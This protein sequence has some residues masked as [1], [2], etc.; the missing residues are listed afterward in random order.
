MK[1]NKK[2]YSQLFTAM[3]V[4]MG[5]SVFTQC[6]KD[7]PEKEKKEKRDKALK[8]ATA[9]ITDDTVASIGNDGKLLN[10]AGGDFAKKFNDCKGVFVNNGGKEED[11]YAE[12]KKAADSQ[13]GKK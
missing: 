4:V 9:L 6:S 13:K 10:G 3:G 1:T 8:D 11:F 12:M 5:M 2:F 7:D